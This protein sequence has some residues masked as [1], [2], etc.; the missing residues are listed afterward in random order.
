MNFSLK[1]HITPEAHARNLIHELQIKTWPINIEEI[2]EKIGLEYV[3]ADLGSND[4]DGGLDLR[5]K[6]YILAVNSRINHT[7]RKNFTGA[8]ELGHFRIPEH[9]NHRYNC[10]PFDVSSYDATDKSVER[11]ANR[12]ATELLMPL[13]LVKNFTKSSLPSF[14]TANAIA[15][16]FQV[17]LTSAAIRMIDAT[18]DAAAV[19]LSK[20]GRI[21]WSSRSKSFKHE[22]YMKDKPLHEYT[23]AIDFSKSS[24]SEMRK[25]EQVVPYA[26]IATR[27]VSENTKLLEHSLYFQDF[28]TVM[29]ILSMPSEEDELED[30]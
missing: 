17:S 6:P 12:F 10:S 24:C 27:G 9:R 20:N 13:E 5:A 14:T 18:E 29:T 4:V 19:V 16:K 23:Y 2:S 7:G 15:E 30:W 25:F 21:L 22:I 1:G 26:W 3:E 8:H 11:E 28:G